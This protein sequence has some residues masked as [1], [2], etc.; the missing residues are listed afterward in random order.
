MGRGSIFMNFGVHFGSHFDSLFGVF[1]DLV[2][3]QFL[4]EFWA[5]FLKILGSILESFLGLLASK[6]HKENCY[7]LEDGPGSSRRGP[8]SEKA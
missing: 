8:G 1:W 2:L 4:H 3:K 5:S 6:I 7:A